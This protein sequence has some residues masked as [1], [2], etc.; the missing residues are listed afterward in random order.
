MVFLV[1]VLGVYSGS[2]LPMEF[3]PSV[4]NP[5]VT[6]TTFGQGM[7]AETMTEKLTD[8]LEKE[9]SNLKYIDTILSSTSEGLS[10]IDIM[11]TSEA[12]MKEATREVEKIIGQIQFPQGV[13][14]P[15]VAQLNTSMI[16][17][18]QIVIQSEKGFTKQDEHN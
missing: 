12:D 10:K 18:S 8:P 9:F 2:K 13:M 4:D 11:Y 1:S 5:V 15:Y 17:I 6:V 7:N 14:K 16:P 3:L